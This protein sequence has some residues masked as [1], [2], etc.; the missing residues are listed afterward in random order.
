[1][2]LI[3]AA[4]D[5]DIVPAPTGVKG[6]WVRG[7]HD[8]VPVIP[9]EA[10]LHLYTMDGVVFRVTDRIREEGGLLI[11]I[12]LA[13]LAFCLLSVDVVNLTLIEAR[14]CHVESHRNSSTKEYV[15]IGRDKSILGKFN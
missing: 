5:T 7:M 6:R 15:F 13:L 12:F 4:A 1:M 10:T 11:F 8:E 9:F 2:L 14:K 3:T